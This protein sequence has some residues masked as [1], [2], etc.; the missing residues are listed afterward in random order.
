M[1]S[2]DGTAAQEERETQEAADEDLRIFETLRISSPRKVNRRR[3]PSYLFSPLWTVKRT[4]A[5]RQARTHASTHAR[6]RLRLPE[7]HA[8]D[9]SMGTRTCTRTDI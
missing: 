8:D 2:D 5:R 3:V 9:Y 7:S 6:M 1:A 4:H